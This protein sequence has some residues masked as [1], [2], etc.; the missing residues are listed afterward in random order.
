MHYEGDIEVEELFELE[1]DDTFLSVEEET[2]VVPAQ[3]S[4]S[5]QLGQDQQQGHILVY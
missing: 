1:K 2:I 3:R 5:C 4:R